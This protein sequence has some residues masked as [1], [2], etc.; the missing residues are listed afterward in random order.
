ME[1]RLHTRNALKLLILGLAVSVGAQGQHFGR[2]NSTLAFPARNPASQMIP[3][4]PALPL[5][6][7]S[8]PLPF[9]TNLVFPPTGNTFSRP[10]STF[11]RPESTYQPL[12]TVTPSTNIYQRGTLFGAPITIYPPQPA[13]P[14]TTSI[15]S[16]NQP[17]E[18]GSDLNPLM[19][20]LVPQSPPVT[21]DY[22]PGTTVFPVPVQ[23]APKLLPPTA[24]PPIF[25]APSANFAVPVQ[26]APVI[27]ID[28][29]PGST[30]RR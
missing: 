8:R 20:P 6:N 4:R 15:T 25:V 2:T 27:S 23:N 21:I 28:L 10:S 30:V 12:Q 24:P 9:Q 22:P 16:L 3:P 11:S 26:P 1:W 7:F 17:N 5:T 13:I 18:L 29:P 14:E 19:E